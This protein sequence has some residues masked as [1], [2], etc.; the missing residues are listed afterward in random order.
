MRAVWL[1]EEAIG[2]P[3]GLAGEVRNSGAM[4]RLALATLATSRSRRPPPAP[5]GG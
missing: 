5:L 1:D 4:A 2:D 3:L